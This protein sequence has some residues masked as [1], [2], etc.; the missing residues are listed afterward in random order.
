MRGAA[1]LASAFPC[2]SQ[3][4]VSHSLTLLYTALDNQVVNDV[5]HSGRSIRSRSLTPPLY[6]SPPP[7]SRVSTIADVL[8]AAMVRAHL[9]E[10]H[11]PV[12]CSVCIVPGPRTARIHM[13]RSSSSSKQITRAPSASAARSRS[14]ASRF[15]LAAAPRRHAEYASR[16]SRGGVLEAFNFR[17]RRGSGNNSSS[18]CKIDYCPMSWYQRLHPRSSERSSSYVEP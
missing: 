2:S 13:H 11:T 14:L 10:S 7:D 17:A 16:G 12:H 6:H 18:G 1:R 9:S 8:V 3:A 15:H 4:N 5:G